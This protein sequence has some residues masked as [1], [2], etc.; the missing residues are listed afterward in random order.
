TLWMGIGSPFFTRRFDVPCQTVLEQ[1]NRSF[2]QE[3][4]LPGSIPKAAKTDSSGR[5]LASTTTPTS[6]ERSGTR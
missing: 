1:M 4:T 6:S 5:I 2:A 3:A